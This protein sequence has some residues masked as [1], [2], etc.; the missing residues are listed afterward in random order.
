MKIINF[1]SLNIDRVYELTDFVTPGATV[2]AKELNTFAGGKGL[3]Q[4]IAAARAGAHVFHVGAVGSDGAF[5]LDL[6]KDAGA[7]VSM[8]KTLDF[9][10]GHAIIQVN[11]NGQNCIIIY[12]GTN[13]KLTRD[14]IDS[15]LRLAEPGDIAL[16][17]N[18]TN[19][20]P[21]IME[22][23]SAH[24]MKV[25]WNPSPIPENLSMF[26]LEKVDYLIVN[27]I[28]GAALAGLGAE[29][30]NFELILSALREKYPKVRVVLTLGDQGVLYEDEAGKASHPVFQAKAVDTTAAGD[31]FCGYFLAGIC[32]GRTV[33]ECLRQASAASS[34]AVSR[35]GAAPSIPVYK[36]VE[37]F[38][39]KQA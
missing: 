20:I 25:A 16:L 10:S 7:D 26:P 8:T 35:S 30:K 28:E 12:G 13:R 1:G 31:T 2:S 22:Q 34:I 14:H 38:L 29:E 19:N 39:E 37:A 3:N 17:Q 5:L 18:E 4:S 9:E 27:E 24:G 23:A 21:Y 32:Q 33:S 11:Q 6:L 36:E 15:A